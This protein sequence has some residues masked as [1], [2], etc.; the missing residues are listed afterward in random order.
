MGASPHER[1]DQE[2]K[3]NL[4]LRREP[5]W[6]DWATAYAGAYVDEPYDAHTNAPSDDV[7]PEPNVA[8]A[9]VVVPASGSAFVAPASGSAAASSGYGPYAPDAA[10]DVA[11]G[12]MCA[13]ELK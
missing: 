4:T 6:E 2:R 1:D 8:A 10:G 7:P 9:R 11:P 3:W 12:I 13:T 5:G